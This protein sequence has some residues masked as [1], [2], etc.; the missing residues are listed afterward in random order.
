M[1]KKKWENTGFSSSPQKGFS[2]FLSFSFSLI[3]FVRSFGSGRSRFDS[4]D[5]R[6]RKEEEEDEWE[7]A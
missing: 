6:K 7:E 4:E 1:E 3:C 2:N 5:I